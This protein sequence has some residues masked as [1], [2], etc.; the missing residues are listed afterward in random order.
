[1]NGYRCFSFKI[2]NSKFKIQKMSNKAS[3]TGLEEVGKTLALLPKKYFDKNARAELLGKAAEPVQAAIRNQ[4]PIGKAA[5]HMSK[6]GI[7]KRGTLQR[8]IQTFKSRKDKDNNAVLVGPVLRKDSKI[9]SVKGAKRVSKARNKR[10]YYANIL[11]AITK[12]SW[13]PFGG[14]RGQ[15]TRKAIDFVK[16]GYNSSRTQAQ[17]RIVQGGNKIIKK[18]KGR[19]RM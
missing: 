9:S 4:T 5:K 11:L 2:Q 3:V 8:S 6:D 19:Y 17:Q 13:T 12:G 15:R 7:K 1:V 14:R 18:F 16:K 10:A